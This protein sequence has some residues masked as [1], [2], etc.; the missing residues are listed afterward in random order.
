MIRARANSELPLTP[1]DFQSMQNKVYEQ[2]SSVLIR[3]GFAPGQKVSSRKLA[4]ALGTSDMPVRA[5]LGKLLAQGGLQQN[6]NGTFSVPWISRSKFREVMELR[7]I[8]EARAAREACGR[9][10][11]QGFRELEKFG[12]GLDA[13]IV[14][15]DIQAYLDFNQRLKF[16]IYGFSQSETLKAHIQLLWL[17]AGPFLRHLNQDLQKMRHANYHDDA[18]AALRAKHRDHVARAIMRDILAGM[19]FLLQNAS[20][21][22]GEPTSGAVPRTGSRSAKR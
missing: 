2:I 19:E 12:A 15:N 7:A 11:Q 22:Q 9:I 13:S 3:G 6:P 14:S 21:S 4:A 16:K 8:L 17:Q 10:D 18:I 20:F 5:A 1:I